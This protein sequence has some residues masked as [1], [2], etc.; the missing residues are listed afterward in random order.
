MVVFKG[1]VAKWGPKHRGGAR[2]PPSQ[3]WQTFVGN[4]FAGTIA[5]DFLTVP[6]VTFGILYVFLV[7]SLARRRLLHVNV[8][9]HPRAT[10]TAQQIVE[11]LGSDAQV[12]RLIRDRD[13]IYGA[14]SDAR[15]DHLGLK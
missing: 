1:G 9:P 6:T 15:A 8:T 4:H 3:T 2:P 12:V 13:G 10:W 11:A 5:I 7:L 14:E